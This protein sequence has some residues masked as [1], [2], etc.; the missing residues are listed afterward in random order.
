MF[1]DDFIDFLGYRNMIIED[2]IEECLSVARRG[3][4]EVTIDVSDL[5]NDEVLY[6]QRE[7]SRR[8]DSS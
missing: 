4:E 5:T 1:K 3:E 7:L 2:R 8:L 6:L